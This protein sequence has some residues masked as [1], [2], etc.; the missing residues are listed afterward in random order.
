MEEYKKKAGCNLKLADMLRIGL[1]MAGDLYVMSDAAKEKN[2]ELANL[3][4]SGADA[5]AAFN[6]QVAE[7]ISNNAEQ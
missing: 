5:F 6:K 3:C 2:V 4:T 1:Q 7:Y